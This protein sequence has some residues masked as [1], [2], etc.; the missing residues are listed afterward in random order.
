LR[1]VHAGDAIVVVGDTD[2]MLVSMR[3]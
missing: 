2:I 3:E 1:T